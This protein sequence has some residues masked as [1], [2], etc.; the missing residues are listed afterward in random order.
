MHGRTALGDPIE[1]GAAV[2][3]LAAAAGFRA[4]RE[5]LE[6]GRDASIV[7]RKSGNRPSSDGKDASAANGKD[8]SAA[9]G[10][11]SPSPSPSPSWRTVKN[12]KTARRR[13]HPH[14]AVIPAFLSGIKSARGHA[15]A[16]AGAWV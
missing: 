14:R 1:F 13:T 7:G 6:G 12:V 3:V 11:P 8:A 15:E 10:T 16:A 5:I 9:N 2:A 4:V